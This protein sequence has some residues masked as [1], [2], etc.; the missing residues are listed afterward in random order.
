M[1]FSVFWK[2]K[3]TVNTP[4]FMPVNFSYSVE[5]VELEIFQVGEKPHDR[6]GKKII[7]IQNHAAMLLSVAD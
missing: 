3:T 2:Q 1:S 7:S 5:S 4:G 6:D